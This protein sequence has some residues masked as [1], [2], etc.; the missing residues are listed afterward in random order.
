MDPLNTSG[1]ARID[2]SIMGDSPSPRNGHG[3]AA[4]HGLLY[5]FGGMGGNID[6][7]GTV[8]FLVLTL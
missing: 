5:V 8:M 2:A 3:F 7:P 1:W 4:A 6:S